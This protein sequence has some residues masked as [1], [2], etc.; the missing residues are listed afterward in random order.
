MGLVSIRN[1][2]DKDYSK[3]VLTIPFFSLLN[4]N[5]MATN[6]NFGPLTPLPLTTLQTSVQ[7]L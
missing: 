7:I 3:S 1:K 4:E 6:D 2:I 5:Q